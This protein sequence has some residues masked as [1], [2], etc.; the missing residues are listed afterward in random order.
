[1]Y[2]EGDAGASESSGCER[3]D[4]SD[5]VVVACALIDVSAI[6]ECRLLLVAVEMWDSLG[7]D[8]E[9]DDSSG[10]Y[11]GQVVVQSSHETMSL[12]VSGIMDE[13][14]KQSAPEHDG[15]VLSLVVSLMMVD[16][17]LLPVDDSLSVRV[18][19]KVLV[20]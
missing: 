18:S 15:W 3:V 5:R 4:I 10:T 17:A 11:V 6:L 19:L 8:F 14:G 1:M 2:L 12:G 9:D 16:R 7:V 20:S 13:S